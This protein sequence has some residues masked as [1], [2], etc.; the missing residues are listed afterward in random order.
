MAAEIAKNA[1]WYHVTT[2]SSRVRATSR[3][4]EA[5]AIV[6]V[7]RYKDAGGRDP[8]TGARVTVEFVAVSKTQP[9]SASSVAVITC[10]APGAR[11]IAS[12]RALA[13][14]TQTMPVHSSSPK[15]GIAF[16]FATHGFHTT[17]V[18]EPCLATTIR[19]WRP[20]SSI[21]TVPV[22]PV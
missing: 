5:K 2:L 12:S 20:G 11:W 6:K 19:R 8:G 4:R 10:E 13:V 3:A 14:S 9:A 18:A 21:V 22:A 7:P 16:A 17:V 15:S 1:R